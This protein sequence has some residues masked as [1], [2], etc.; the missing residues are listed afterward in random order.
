MAENENA[1]SASQAML[2]LRTQV[3]AAWSSAA[4]SSLN[5]AGRLPEPILL[6]TLPAFYDS[7]AQL[8]TCDSGV[9]DVSVI[10][11]E[12]GG[13][14]ARLSGYDTTALIE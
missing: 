1:S 7:L 8:L 13:E 9:E 5:K 2:A 11:Q 10:A 6:N 4:R 3:I 14:R 12:H